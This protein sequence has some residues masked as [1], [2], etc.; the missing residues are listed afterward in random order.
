MQ[1]ILTLSS[2]AASGLLLS[3]CASL[4]TPAGLQAG[5]TVAVVNSLSWDNPL[6]GKRAGVRTSCP[7]KDGKMAP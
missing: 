7:I 6:T 1:R 4:G 2:L 3:A 5:Q